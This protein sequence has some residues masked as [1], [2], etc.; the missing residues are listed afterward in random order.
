MN[1]VTTPKP[2]KR[3]LS[4]LRDLNKGTDPDEQTVTNKSIQ[5]DKK[6]IK[7]RLFIF[8]SFPYSNSD[9]KLLFRAFIII[10]HVQSNVTIKLTHYYVVSS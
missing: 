7:S 2:K 10:I 1:E 5:V 6:E 3:R 4:S 9:S 8:I